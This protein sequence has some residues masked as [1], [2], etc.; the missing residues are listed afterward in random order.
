DGMRVYLSR[1][2]T[3]SIGPSTANNRGGDRKA[4]ANF[5]QLMLV[6]GI[7]RSKPLIEAVES[8]PREPFVRREYKWSVEGSK[9]DVAVLDVGP[10]RP[11]SEEPIVTWATA[12][13]GPLSVSSPM[14]TI[15]MLEHARL[16][17]RHDV[18]EIGTGTGYSTALLAVAVG[19]AGH[20]SSVERESE[21]S[22]ISRY[23]LAEVGLSGVEVTCADGREVMPSGSFDRV[24][25]WA[26]GP[27]PERA[28]LERL[29]PGGRLI[30]PVVLDGLQFVLKVDRSTIAEGF[31]GRIVGY[32]LTP[33]PL[34]RG[35]TSSPVDLLQ[36]PEPWSSVRAGAEKRVLVRDQV[37]LPGGGLGHRRLL[38]F[39]FY[40]RSHGLGVTLYRAPP[41]IGMSVHVATRDGAWAV[42]SGEVI[43]GGGE[44]S[45]AFLMA[46]RILERWHR[47][48][49]PRLADYRLDIRLRSENEASVPADGR[50]WQLGR[51]LDT[52]GGLS[53]RLI[54]PKA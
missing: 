13:L 11:Y 16:K 44:S 33:M 6:E 31:E 22:G 35:E 28:W 37:K 46:K 53:C 21:L 4:R 17:P 32:S 40:A 3:M 47:L 25:V 50:I 51:M 24:V 18:L 30:M 52:G 48:G 54:H 43:F 14:A 34:L 29:R 12:L 10:E 7:L 2:E 15:G 41:P 45:R 38:D 26:A 23:A 9:G 8:I 36:Q 1:R 27:M 5:V 49:C 42:V 20:V 19:N 39:W